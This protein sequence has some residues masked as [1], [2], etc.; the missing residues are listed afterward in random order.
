[1]VDGEQFQEYVQEALAHLY[2]QSYLQIHPL[3][4]LVA[5]GPVEEARGRALYRILV[6]VIDQLKPPPEAPTSSPA[7]R[8]YRYLVR[9]YVES[10]TAE[11]VAQELGVTE[12]QA[13][14]DHH[15][16]VEAVAS[17]LWD[18][19]V[20]SRP[21]PWEEPAGDASTPAQPEVAVPASELEA[22][23]RRLADE[24]PRGPTALGEV[25][26]GVVEMA[27]RLAE[28]KGV[29]LSFSVPDDLPPLAVDRIVLRQILLGLLNHGVEQGPRASIHLAA[30]SGWAHVELRATLSAQEPGAELTVESLADDD[31]G[32]IEASR[33]LLEAQGGHLSIDV[34]DRRK[35]TVVLALPVARS[36]TVLVVDDNPDL[37]LL[38]QRYLGKSHQVV[39]ACSAAEA[40]R[41]S[42]E[43]KPDVIT[44]DVLMPSQDGYELLQHLRRDEETRDIPVLVCSVL[45]EGALALSLGASG[46]VPKPVTPEALRAALS[47]CQARRQAERQGCHEDSGRTRLPIDR[48]RE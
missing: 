18:R 24:A 33:R 47:H 30:T 28:S 1:M 22:E 26:A 34:S 11:R 25:V 36:T 31:L 37:G 6:G 41:L 7:W 5:E 12:R 38:F 3:A 27:R 19:H 23:V 16:A 13:R 10:A 9:R 4:A 29:E 21:R 2:D 48:R 46:F 14:R 42:R 35:L 44:L 20:R 39:Q 32:L 45:R 40:F 8:K 17:I 15:D 43:I